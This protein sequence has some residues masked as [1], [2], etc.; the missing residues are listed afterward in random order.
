[1]TKSSATDLL[2]LARELRR[3]A[4][5]IGAPDG[6][7]PEL[8]RPR[9]ATHGDLAS[10]VALVLAKQLGE[11]PRDLALRIEN[12]FDPAAA[13]VA[14]VQVA[15]LGFLNFRLSDDLVWER[16]AKILATADRYGRSEPRKAER[17]NVEFVSANPTGPLH[18]AHGRGAALGDAIA[19][20]L[21]WT[22]HEIA[23][24]FYVN[25]TGRQI[26]LLAESVEARLLELT[27]TPTPIP[28]GGYHGEY[29]VELAREMSSRI[30][31]ESLFALD[32]DERLR[33]IEAE[34]VRRLQD[35]QARDLLDFH[36]EMDLFYSERSLHESGS[37]DSLVRRF[38]DASLL[39][40]QDGATWLRTTAFGDEKDRVLVK[41]D[42]AYTYFAP[43]LAYH[44]DKAERGYDRAI[45]VWGADHQGHEQRMVAALAGLGHA[46][47][48]EVVILQLVTVLRG[49]V[50]ARMSKRAGRF[51]TLRELFQETGV[52]VARYFFLM[53]RAEVHLNFDLDLALD[54]SEV[55][56][57][58]KIQ[59]A[60]AR[61]CS[62][63][64][65]GQV[66]P[67]SLAA[68][69]TGLE[70]LRTDAERAV[71]TSLLRLPQVIQAAA[72]SRAPHMLCAYLEEVAGLVNSWY[73]QGNLDP[74]LRLL[75]EG[76]EREGRL[77]L[78]RATQITLR[79]GLRLL[80]LSAP[81]K[82][83]REDD[84]GGE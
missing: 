56:P 11:A 24:E 16:L 66:D 45:D 81:Q 36:I 1:M 6:F 72:E 68:D 33:R 60:H 40:E 10:N 49:G 82:M 32:R 7:E 83:V 17:I 44:L 79:N 41:R 20:L 18:V 29:V 59:Y 34:S 63:F 62:V 71:A 5:E 70:E 28:D 73:H 26:R 13:G 12:A 3:A 23:R 43:D 69:A 52:D 14:E 48:L 50:E 38:A 57:V 27:G 54:T 21:E 78:A 84:D 53:R 37:V 4:Q 15:G 9:D 25:D 2:D 19:S 75:V 77:K 55:N 22:G 74:A 47:L 42:G 67:S 51:V 64:A 46:E 65:R 80:G 76:P 31:T 8:T 39:Y 61:M 30:G 58:Y 35:E